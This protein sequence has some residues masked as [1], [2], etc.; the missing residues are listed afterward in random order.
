MWSYRVWETEL[1]YTLMV[2]AAQAA[3]A[4]VALPNSALLRLTA[5]MVTED[6]ISIEKL[7]GSF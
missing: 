7:E 6:V 3:W 2:T 5:E 4:A 1:S